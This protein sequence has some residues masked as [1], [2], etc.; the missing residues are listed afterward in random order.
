MARIKDPND[1]KTLLCIA[2]KPHKA[3][4]ELTGLRGDAVSISEGFDTY[5]EADATLKLMKKKHAAFFIGTADNKRLSI[6]RAYD[7]QFLELL[8]FDVVT[9]RSSADFPTVAPE[10]YTKYFVV[11]QGIADSRIENMF[12]DLF[13]QRTHEVALGG[14]RYAWI[15]SQVDKVFTLKYVRVL[16][17]LTVEDIGPFF[18]LRLSAEF[19][20]GDD[21]WTTALNIQKVKKQR[22][23]EKTGTKDRIGKLHIDRQDLKGIK[24]KKTKGYKKR[25]S[26]DDYS[27]SSE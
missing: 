16:N 22:N 13:H 1:R 18:E 6:G 4:L 10:P 11:C 20:C 26:K 17:D 14:I 21:V 7:G 15:I 19:T 2:K 23:T 9:V 27:D 12:L 5:K 25:G 3:I 8:A 24:L